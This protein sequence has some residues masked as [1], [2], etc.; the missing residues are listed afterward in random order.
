[1]QKYKYVRM[2][3]DGQKCCQQQI[4]P[5]LHVVQ[6]ATASKH[7]YLGALW[8]KKP[9]AIFLFH[10]IYQHEGV[11]MFH[12]SQEDYT[13]FSQLRESQS[14]FAVHKNLIQH[15]EY[16]YQHEG[17]QTCDNPCPGHPV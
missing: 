9:D 17:R 8:R 3:S 4:V 14:S 12:A 15:T 1:M 10:K 6:A 13:S 16:E 11:R 7:K 2:I 5:L